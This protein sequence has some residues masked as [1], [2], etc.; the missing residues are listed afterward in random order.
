MGVSH[1]W[2][3]EGRKP[4]QRLSRN[5]VAKPRQ[6]PR[7][8]RPVDVNGTRRDTSGKGSEAIRS[9][10]L[11]GLRFGEDEDAM[12]AVVREEAQAVAHPQVEPRRGMFGHLARDMFA[13]PQPAKM[14]GALRQPPDLAAVLAGESGARHY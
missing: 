1:S 2:Q 13:I 11:C 7:K 8:R 4:S 3:R 12:A 6:R 9:S 14:G 10:S 5:G